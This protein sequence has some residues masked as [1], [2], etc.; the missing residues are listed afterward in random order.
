MSGDR[1]DCRNNL[2]NKLIAK[3]AFE[4]KMK[5]GPISKLIITK[6]G[7]RPTQYNKVI[8]TLFV[9]CVDKNYQGIN[10]IIMNGINR[11]KTDFIPPYPDA[12]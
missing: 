2:Q 4:G 5:D 11:V 8:Y 10:D 9:L 1:V 3:Y 6:E 12:T 7:H